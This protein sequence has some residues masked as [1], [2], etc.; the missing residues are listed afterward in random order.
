MTSLIYKVFIAVTST[1]LE[2]SSTEPEG[3]MRNV[4]ASRGML[5]AEEIYDTMVR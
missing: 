1:K 4:L 5:A 2:R 3:R